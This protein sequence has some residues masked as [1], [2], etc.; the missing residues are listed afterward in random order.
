ME[1]EQFANLGDRLDF[2][3]SNKEHLSSQSESQSALEVARRLTFILFEEI[4][5]NSPTQSR[6]VIF[7]PGSCKEDLELL[8][9]VQQHG[10]VTSII[11]RELEDEEQGN[12]P[13]LVKNPGERTF[14]LVA[15]HR[16]VAAGRAAGLAGTE[17]VIAK[18]NEDHNLITLVENMG[19]RELTTYEKAQAYKSLQKRRGLSGNKTAQL[20]GISQGSINR[21]FNA[22][23]SPTALRE[24]WQDG[25]LSDT[26]IMILK[27]HW[28]EI[29]QFEIAYIKDKLRGLARSD[30]VS[31]RDQLGSGTP[32][33]T[34]LISMDRINDPST[35]STNPK[36]T[37]QSRAPGR[38]KEKPNSREDHTREQKYALISAINDVFPKI[39]EEKGKVLYDYTVV[40]G[41][42]DLDVLWAAA[43]YVAK[44]GK[45]D[46]SV[47]LSAK[48]MTNRKVAGLINRQVKQEKQGAHLYKKYWK[49][50][51]DLKKYLKSVFR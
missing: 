50:N 26:S 35:L 21:M 46:E 17:G 29:G 12:D 4:I 30:A 31:L 16:R 5:E 24:L 25:Y 14:A 13:F 39:S 6:T 9:S 36:P 37:K 3:V 40:N 11:V 43:L 42:S 8:E 38:V 27:D 1:S 22:L 45:L 34:A 51:P 18:P 10:I 23:K 2:Q 47:V 44:G 7:E 48:V 49:K 28:E 20:A 19:R 41:I 32:L 33:K 15:G